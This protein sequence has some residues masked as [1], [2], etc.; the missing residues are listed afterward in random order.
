MKKYQIAIIANSTS[1]LNREVL[2]E[3]LGEPQNGFF[4]P[5]EF[6]WQGLD[7]AIIP[8]DYLPSDVLSPNKTAIAQKSLIKAIEYL[9]ER[10]IKLICLA[11]STKRLGGKGGEL[12]KKKIS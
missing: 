7:G 3:L 11:A 1:L 6:E 10:S 2:K 5:L 8:L 4:K 9:E 12:L